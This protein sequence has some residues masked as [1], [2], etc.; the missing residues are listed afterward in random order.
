VVLQDGPDEERRPGVQTPFLAVHRVSA[1]QLT[2]FLE[3]EEEEEEEEERT[4]GQ[5]RCRYESR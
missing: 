5:I 1:Q 3:E 4:T 2:G